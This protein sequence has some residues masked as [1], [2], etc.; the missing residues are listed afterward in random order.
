MNFS[1]E[2]NHNKIGNIFLLF[3]FL[4]FA[5]IQTACERNNPKTQNP[6]KPKNSPSTTKDSEKK[7]EIIPQSQAD[8][9][10]TRI[11]VEKYNQNHFTHR[12]IV[13]VKNEGSAVAKGFDGVARYKCEPGGSGGTTFVGGGYIGDKSE[14]TYKHPFQFMCNVTPAYVDFEFEIDPTNK[15]AESN[16]SNNR[17][18]YRASMY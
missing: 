16:E 17:T 8:L 11:V 15:V 14:F 1:K 6:S 7:E 4:I 5:L 18:N 9:R 13:T 10:I 12:I 2:F 3:L